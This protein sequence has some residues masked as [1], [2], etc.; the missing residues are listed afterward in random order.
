M[1]EFKIAEKYLVT[2]KKRRHWNSFLLHTVQKKKKIIV[3]DMTVFPDRTN[4][5]C[6]GGTADKGDWSTVAK[7]DTRDKIWKAATD[8]LPMLKVS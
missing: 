4:S 2:Q 6:V 3:I 8:L 1:A 7:K 5:I